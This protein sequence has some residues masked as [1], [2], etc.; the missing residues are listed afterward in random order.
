LSRVYLS[1]PHLTGAEAE[2]VAAAF[3]SNW[4]APLGPEVDAFEAELA[5]ACGVGHA[6]A[7]SSGT[8]ALHLALLLA[9][10]ERGDEVWCSDLTFVASVNAAVYCGAVPVLVD[11]DPATWTLD[12]ALVAEELAAAARRGRLPRALVAVDLYGQCCDYGALEPLC[13]EHGVTLI[14]DAAEALGGT[15]LGRPAG[16]FG[17]FAALSFNGNKIITTSGGGALVG[18]D[19]EGIARARFLASQAREPG[20]HYEHE[21]LGFNYRL[22]NLLA[23]VGR[24]QLA[25]LAQRVAARRAHFA[26]YRELLGGLPGLD[27]MPEAPYG[28]SN[29]WLTVITLDPAAF[30][31]DRELVRQALEAEDIE[32]RPVWKPMHLQPLYAGERCLGGTVGEALFARGLCL[33]S[34]SNL[35]AADLDR[36]VQIVHRCHRP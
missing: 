25:T 30:G 13:A 27:F 16:A 36:V 6:A 8:A 24:G 19:G 10:V 1:P 28:T 21:T 29:R 12:P 20:P 33:P 17:R 32:A 5:A 26:R 15:C 2:R 23:A 3:A 4:I 11:A 9:G 7:L 35:A 18:D 34:G 14:E 31:A 22:S